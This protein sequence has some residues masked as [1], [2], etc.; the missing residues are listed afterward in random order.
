MIPL[1]ALSLAAAIQ[2]ATPPLLGRDDALGQARTI[3]AVLEAAR[4]GRA[5]EL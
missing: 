2:G 5:V 1:A 3:A 4:S